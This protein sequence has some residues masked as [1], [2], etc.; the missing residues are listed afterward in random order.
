MFRHTLTV[1]CSSVANHL[2]HMA[3]GAQLQRLQCFRLG[4]QV[5]YSSCLSHLQCICLFLFVG[6]FLFSVKSGC[7]LQ[8]LLLNCSINSDKILILCIF[9][10][11]TGKKIYMPILF[12]MQLHGCLLFIWMNSDKIAG[13][14]SVAQ[15]SAGKSC[16]VPDGVGSPKIGVLIL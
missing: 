15:R 12:Q 6:Y 9:K 7:L 5:C 11:R 2:M 14:M 1:L 16:I 13:L 3:T 8:T 10:Y 4:R